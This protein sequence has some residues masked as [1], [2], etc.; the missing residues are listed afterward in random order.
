MSALT[1]YLPASPSLPADI[2]NWTSSSSSS[3]H[4]KCLE[5][6]LPWMQTPELRGKGCPCS[7]V[8]PGCRVHSKAFQQCSC[9]WINCSNFI[10]EIKTPINC[11]GNTSQDQKGVEPGPRKRKEGRRNPWK[12]KPSASLRVVERSIP[13]WNGPLAVSTTPWF[14]SACARL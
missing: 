5:I 9:P 2:P 8:T 14:N 13:S 12:G 3:S 7:R 6:I 4:P 1:L 11:F 10:M